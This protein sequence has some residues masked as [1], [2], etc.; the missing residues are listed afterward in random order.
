MKHLVNFTQHCTFVISYRYVSRH[1]QCGATNNLVCNCLALITA[2]IVCHTALTK[3]LLEIETLFKILC[4]KLK[5][6]INRNL[7]I[8][9]FIF[10]LENFHKINLF[11]NN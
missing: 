5:K 2:Q 6:N 10:F 11:I 9:F 4:N 1:L 3:M 8:I 7:F